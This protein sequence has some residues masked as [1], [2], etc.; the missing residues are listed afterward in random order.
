MPIASWGIRQINWEASTA[1]L[2][3]ELIAKRVELTRLLVDYALFK[4]RDVFA[5]AIAMG[6]DRAIEGMRLKAA[7][8]EMGERYRAFIRS[9]DSGQ[10]IDDW[11]SYRYEALAM[12][13]ELHK[14]LISERVAIRKLLGLRAKDL[15]IEQLTIEEP[16]EELQHHG[17][18]EHIDYI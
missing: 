11:S 18:D 8:I 9:P 10:R 6:G 1:S 7:C 3:S 17:D 12:A 13:I 15:P 14:H 5:P 16:A 2:T 4:H